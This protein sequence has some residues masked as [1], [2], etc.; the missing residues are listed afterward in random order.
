MSGDNK[1]LLQLIFLKCIFISRWTELV[2]NTECEFLY[3][4]CRFNCMFVTLCLCLMCHEKLKSDFYMRL[5]VD[6]KSDY[7]Y[8]IYFTTGN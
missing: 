1:L 5:F 2:I 3:I 6:S 8:N 7:M 4:L